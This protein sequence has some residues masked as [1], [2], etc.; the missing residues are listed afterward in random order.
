MAAR[1][2]DFIGVIKQS[3]KLY[4]KEFLQEKLGPMPAGSRLIMTS[5][6]LGQDLVSIGYKYNRKKVLFF[7]AT[8][9]A[10]DIED[11]QPYV[12]RWAD[13]Y[14]NIMTRDIPRPAVLSKY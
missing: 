14:N 4:P 12:Q 6:V 7:V 9:G 13:E 5:N 3:H 11:G 8:P 1:G 10:G 2:Y